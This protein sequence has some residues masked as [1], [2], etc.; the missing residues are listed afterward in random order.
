MSLLEKYA[1]TKID[2]RRFLKVAG[3]GG[4]GAAALACSSSVKKAQDILSTPESAKTALQSTFAVETQSGLRESERV[5]I[6]LGNWDI[7][8]VGWEKFDKVLLTSNLQSEQDTD[9]KLLVVQLIARNVSNELLDGEIVGDFSNFY[10]YRV[11]DKDG[12]LIDRLYHTQA[13][14]Y[15]KT[16][17]IYGK[18]YLRNETGLVYPI[19]NIVYAET[20]FV[21]PG[22]AIPIGIISTLD[23]SAEEYGLA[24]EPLQ[25]G[26][27]NPNNVGGQGEGAKA[28]PK[29]IVRIGEIRKDVQLISPDAK[30]SN[31][32]E[33]MRFT[34]NISGTSAVQFEFRGFSQ[35]QPSPE[36]D[37]RQYI[38][39][40]ATNVSQSVAGS[41][42]AQ[43][44]LIS[45]EISL[46]V[47][48]YNSDIQLTIYLED[49]R[50]ISA[51]GSAK[52]DKLGIGMSNLISIPVSSSRRT[53]RFPT[54]RHPAQAAEDNEEFY[55]LV[56][57]GN[58]VV[59]LTDGKEWIAW[60]ND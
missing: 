23:K 9:H 34:R 51:I 55:G 7:D 21:P 25:A 10:R 37:L 32:N 33:P 44:G 28:D 39:L 42:L 46:D 47:G 60:K 20:Y 4:F 16:G 18:P 12:N 11:A 35:P 56:E 53:S 3:A 24:I 14:P 8:V 48:E 31:K 43:R 19:S 59:V 2:R 15:I 40:N 52:V 27:P 5:L 29:T 38:Q 41:D 58:S 17:G 57:L 50:V 26:I 30:I 49:G 22:F 13:F 1:F 36:G 6:N 45:D 54:I